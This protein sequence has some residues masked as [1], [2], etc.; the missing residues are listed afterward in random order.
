MYCERHSGKH[1]SAPAQTHIST[2]WSSS[3]AVPSDARGRSSSAAPPGASTAQR[4]PSGTKAAK[5]SS[6]RSSASPPCAISGLRLIADE[7]SA[8]PQSRDARPAAEGEAD[9]RAKL[10]E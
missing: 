7:K 10:E 5:K 8:Q 6:C 9:A 3:A 4:A 1:L 2:G